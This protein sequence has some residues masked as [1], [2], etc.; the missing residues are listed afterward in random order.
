[1]KRPA[2]LFGIA[3]FLV[4]AQ[5]VTRAAGWAE[6]TSAVA[7]M[8]HS[9]ASWVLGPA[10]IALQLVVVVVAPVLAIAGTIDTLLS[11]RRRGSND[12]LVPAAR[13]ERG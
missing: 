5:L 8:P 10:F 9:A 2:M 6:H 11:L 7:G 12:E 1:M 4:S 13:L 3:A